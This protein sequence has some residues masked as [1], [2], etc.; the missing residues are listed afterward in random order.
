[1]MDNRPGM[2]FFREDAYELVFTSD[3]PV[4]ARSFKDGTTG[5]LAPVDLADEN[6]VESLRRGQISRERRGSFC[7]GYSNQL[8]AKRSSSLG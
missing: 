1:M 6:V 7:W 4:V 5:K 2:V 8:R 3:N